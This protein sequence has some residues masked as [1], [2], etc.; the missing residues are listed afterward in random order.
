MCLPIPK[1]TTFSER[2][3]GNKRSFCSEIDPY[4]AENPSEVFVAVDEKCICESDQ[5]A[6]RTWYESTAK[7]PFLF[8][9]PIIFVK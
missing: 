6:C 3:T 4:I 9:S 1:L 7:K 5:G 2:V 8:I